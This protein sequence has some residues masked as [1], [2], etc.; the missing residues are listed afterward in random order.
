SPGGEG[1]AMAR[2]RE[3]RL[4]IARALPCRLLMPLPSR[5]QTNSVGPCTAWFA[6]TPPPRPSF[7]EPASSCAP[8][9]N[10]SP[11]TCR[12]PRSWAAR[13]ARS[14]CGGTASWRLAWP[15]CRTPL[16]P[17][18]RRSF[19]PSQRL[20]VHEL[21]T[22]EDPAAAGCPSGSW[23]LDDLALTILQEANEQDLLLAQLA[24]AHE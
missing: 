12:S 2:G 8:L 14:R 6:P 18:G 4:T 23:S 17:A 21:A 3:T 15:A 16:A 9:T 5:C 13:T 19:P 7:A 1:V 22:T 10:T 11:P 24:A 20:H